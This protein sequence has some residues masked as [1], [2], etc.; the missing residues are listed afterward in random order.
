MHRRTGSRRRRGPV[1]I[2][3][4]LAGAVALACSASLNLAVPPPPPA[5]ALPAVAWKDQ[6]ILTV[7]L[8][9]YAGD[10]ADAGFTGD[11]SAGSNDIQRYQFA[12]DTPAGQP[13]R[14]QGS[15]MF[16][17][18]LVGFRDHVGHIKE[19]GATTTVIYP[20][21]EADRQ[22]FL[23][24]LPTGYA[25][26]DFRRL[27]ANFRTGGQPATD[28]S[29]YTDLVDDLHD[30]AIGGYR[31]NVLQDLPMAGTGT[32]HAWFTPEAAAANV[33][34][35]RRWDPSVIAN[36]NGADGSGATTFADSVVVDI[37]GTFD[38]DAFS[39]ADGTG[40]GDL[41]GVGGSLPAEGVGAASYGVVGYDSYLGYRYGPKLNGRPNATAGSATTARSFGFPAALRHKY[42]TLGVAAAAVGGDQQVTFRVTYADATTTDTTLTVPRW[43]PAGAP[44]TYLARFP[45]RHTRS[46]PVQAPVYLYSLL[47][48]TD[49]TK[50]V[51]EVRLLP[52]AGAARTRVFG[53]SGLPVTA[54]ARA[55]LSA[56]YNEDGIATEAAPGDGDLTGSTLLF[57]K[58]GLLRPLTPDVVGVYP[59]T[60]PTTPTNARFVVG[61]A[62]PGRD[63]MVRAEGQA[64]DVVDQRYHYIRLAAFAT[65]G[66]ARP[67]TFRVNYADGTTTDTVV[68]VKP[69]TAAADAGDVLVHQGDHALRRTAGGAWVRDTGVRPKVWGY[70]LAADWEKTVTSITLPDDADVHVVGVSTVVLLDSGYGMPLLDHADG[71]STGTGTFGELV[72]T[73][74]FWTGLGVDGLRIDSA[75]TYRPAALAQACGTYRAVDG[76]D[77]WLLGEAAV[78][79]PARSH[80]LQQPL[81]WQPRREAYTNPSGGVGFTGVYDFETADALRDTF[82]RQ[83]SA[84]ADPDWSLVRR[85]IEWDG[86]YEEPWNQ[87][88]FFDVYEN[89]P[90]LAYA[91][92]AT[93][94]EKLPRIR[95]AAA[96]LFA[97]NRIPMLFT[98]DEYLV[99]YGG[100]EPAGA[101]S[102]RPGYL[103]SPAVAA[104]P[105]YLDNFAYMKALVAM[106]K[107]QPA[108]SSAERMTADSWFLQRDD[109]FGFVRRAS[110]GE[111]VVA[112]FNNSPDPVAGF[113]APLPAGVTGGGTFNYVRRAG[114]TYGADDPTVSFPRPGTLRISSMA[115]WEAKIVQIAG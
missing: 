5:A 58:E 51:V 26:R 76:A 112:V 66:S 97:I 19:L 13:P 96:Y 82:G 3:H 7:E 73:M 4:S 77:R 36:N 11:N 41:D 113:D 71:R 105:T 1:S 22:E 72:G 108:L 68:T 43:D 35:Y 70:Q 33:D 67:A 25:V 12:L 59:A 79:E 48:D 14:Y 15:G 89:Q 27:D 91:D 17:G 85:S 32:E 52:G 61:P 39:F 101:D 107:G 60:S 29:A 45:A 95:M 64:V 44:A 90:F 111:Q 81:P 16:G 28:F 110:T 88:A 50:E 100:T 24:F 54:P 84:V 8:A 74:R 115:P 87:V 98:G 92:G 30:P 21:M 78:R 18:D 93:Y 47:L 20:V 37:A 34:R 69:M 80:P 9:K 102:R 62:A 109:L 75:Q 53:I 40:D 86:R 31:V 10:G 106:R 46:G 104:D 49:P 57:P 94:A 65:G 2:G 55:D 38:T 56:Y 114:A 42:G 83:V 23:G 103:F 99:N 6:V 63:N